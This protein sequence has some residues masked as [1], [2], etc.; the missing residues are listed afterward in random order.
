MKT[1]MTLATLLVLGASVATFAPNAAA[2]PCTGLHAEGGVNVCGGISDDCIG[3]EVAVGPY[4]YVCGGLHEKC[5]GVK[6]NHRCAGLSSG[7]RLL[8]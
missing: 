4:T 8:A 1:S 5:T 6:L 3:L 2:H 7:D